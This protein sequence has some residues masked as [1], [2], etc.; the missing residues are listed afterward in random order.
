MKLFETIRKHA[1]TAEQLTKYRL[2]GSDMKYKDINFVAVY[3]NGDKI[4]FALGYNNRN[5]I[6]FVNDIRS[7]KVNTFTN[8][9]PAMINFVKNVKFR[10]P[11]NKAEIDLFADD[12]EVDFHI[13]GDEIVKNSKGDIT[14]EP[15]KEETIIG[16]FD[17]IRERK[18][19]KLPLIIDKVFKNGL[20]VSE[21]GPFKVSKINVKSDK[22]DS[23]DASLFN[24]SLLGKNENAISILDDETFIDD[25]KFIND[26]MIDEKLKVIDDDLPKVNSTKDLENLLKIKALLNKTLPLAPKGF[27]GD[28]LIPNGPIKVIGGKEIGWPN[29]II[30][31]NENEAYYLSNSYFGNNTSWKKLSGDFNK[32]LTEVSL[33][34]DEVEVSRKERKANIGKIIGN[35]NEVGIVKIN[36]NDKA[37]IDQF[38]Q[39]IDDVYDD[40]NRNNLKND[41]QI[42]NV[43]GKNNNKNDDEY[44]KM[45]KQQLEGISFDHIVYDL[46]NNVGTR[47]EDYKNYKNRAACVPIGVLSKCIKSSEKEKMRVGDINSSANNGTQSKNKKSNVFMVSKAKKLESY[48]CKK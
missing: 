24:D 28:V 35:A 20:D 25:K 7:D 26:Q 37:T 3:R 38:N 2:D 33:Q 34:K 39:R 43:K 8:P 1:L 23:F 13:G 14:I 19:K 15:I 46:R 48:C 22:D 27:K 12:P 4:G 32:L 11:L 31:V 44:L 45:L 30:R 21:E 6:A 41:V 40:F 10:A 29:L 9:G 36:V 5:G 18:E 16:V 47:V 42:H 17:G